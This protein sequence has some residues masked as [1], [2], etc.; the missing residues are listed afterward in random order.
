M[1]AWGHKNKT[2]GIVQKWKTWLHIIHLAQVRGDQET[3]RAIKVCM[4]DQAIRDMLAI[5][6][7]H[8]KPQEESCG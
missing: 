1:S 6:E 5:V 7:E 8:Q 2:E 3:V 4:T